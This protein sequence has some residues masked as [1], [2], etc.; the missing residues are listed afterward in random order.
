VALRVGLLHYTAP[1]VV[2][3]VE[4]V[5]GQHA[6]LMAEAGHRVRIITGR[7]GPRDRRLE[8]VRIPLADTRHPAIR[9]MRARLDRGQVPAGFGGLVAEIAIA[10]RAALAG[11]DVVVAHNVCGLHFNLPLTAALHDLAGEAGGP[12]LI[13]WQHD[14]AW[15][16]ARFAGEL[17]AGYPWDLLR[18][19]WPRTTYV[20][21][22]ET[23]R[24]ELA[25][26]TGLPIGSVRLVP[27][28][29][30][31]ERL[32][33]IHPATRRILEGLGLPG[34]GPVLLVPVRITPRKNL[35]LA[36]GIVAALRASGDDARL[37]VT[38]P[39]DPHASG[40]GAGVARLRTI[41]REARV[42]GAI[43]LLAVDRGRRTPQ[44][45]VSDL[46]RVADALLLP[47]HDEG[48]GLPVLEAA[49]ARLP[50]FCAD[51]P[52]LRELAGDDATYFDPAADP[53]AVAAIIRARLA[54]EP[55]AR[56]AMR[57]RR[58]YGWRAIYRSGVEAVLAE[59]AGRR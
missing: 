10:L 42:E 2:G 26:L 6:R 21:V 41:A 24:N 25:R 44:R 52:T 35:E 28:G 13:A 48:F 55:V 19:A 53:A 49:A 29:V 47:S 30:E 4:V 54:S 15:T 7:G 37:I 11:L 20:A 12:G 18:A 51:I 14:L 57:V 56:L 3:G 33:A 58:T 39:P 5:L 17:H 16:S 38:G 34:P 36:I 23:R 50:V 45:V 59:V 9:A 27:N 43:H 1:P 31:L 22:S 40:S 32:L 8:A 46:Y